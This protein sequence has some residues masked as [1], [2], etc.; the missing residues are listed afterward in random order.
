MDALLPIMEATGVPCLERAREDARLRHD[1]HTAIL[2]GAV[3]HLAETRAFSGTLVA[4]FQPAEEGG[5]GAKVM[6]EGG[7]FERFS[8][9][10]VYALHNM[11]GMEVGTLTL[12]NSVML[13]ASDRFNLKIVGTGGHAAPNRCVISSSTQIVTSITVTKSSLGNG[14]SGLSLI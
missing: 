9:E 14:S 11:P 1:G 5:G 6:V 3:K 13:A 12:S 4:I 10:E 2:L 7:L 8:I